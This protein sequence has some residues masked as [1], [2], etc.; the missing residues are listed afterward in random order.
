[1]EA[2]DAP[3]AAADARATPAALARR[4]QVLGAAFVLLFAAYVAVQVLQT[5]LNG[6]LGYYANL[7]AYFCFALSCTVA[8]LVVARAGT[9]ACL[10]FAS[11][12]YVAFM[13][14]NLTPTPYLLLAASAANGIAAGPLWVSQATYVGAAASASSAATGDALTDAASRMNALFF[15]PFQL[16]GATGTVFS[17]VLLL[18]VAGPAGRSAL[19]LVL[20][21]VGGAGALLL[22]FLEDADAHGDA[23]LRAPW[24]ARAAADKRASAEAAAGADAVA[25][26]HPLRLVAFVARDA[27]L[28][29]LLPLFL[30][31]GA[32]QVRGRATGR[33]GPHRGSFRQA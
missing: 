22:F 2:P 30:A 26:S 24:R 21:F 4:V 13:L 15:T 8:P 3:A 9:R 28:V 10:S 25:A 6:V 19:F 33:D 5:S 7:T 11:L 27:R 16:S 18:A 20:S 14:A 31:M 17:G 23:V 1:M 29:A 32:F 12:A